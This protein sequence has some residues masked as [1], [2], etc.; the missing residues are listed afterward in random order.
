M[1]ARLLRRLIDH[2]AMLTSVPFT[3]SISRYVRRAAAC[4]H[5]AM[6]VRW[7]GGG[8]VIIMR[9]FTHSATV[10]AESVFCRDVAGLTD[11]ALQS[12]HRVNQLQ[13]LS[14]YGASIYACRCL[15]NAG[16]F[17][18]WGDL[19]TAVL[20][21]KSAGCRSKPHKGS[22]AQCQLPFPSFINQHSPCLFDAERR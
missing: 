2:V 22:P 21:Y 7:V 14:S 20:L 1:A 17:D 8:S 9:G 11:T 3:S 10:A 6:L 12:Q 5:D 18:I 16:Y 13:M 19:L 15:D 4:V